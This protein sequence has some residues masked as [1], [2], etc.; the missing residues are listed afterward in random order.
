MSIP[1]NCDEFITWLNDFDMAKE[2]LH[3]SYL[4]HTK[5]CDNCMEYLT[6]FH[7][8]HMNKAVK[9]GLLV[10]C[11]RCGNKIWKD[12]FTQTEWQ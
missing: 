2:V 1:K 10:I 6:E 12:E 5:E 8:F 9:N 3:L 11:G 4:Q 7:K